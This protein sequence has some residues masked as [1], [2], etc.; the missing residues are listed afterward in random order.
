M[1]IKS[2]EQEMA[3]FCFNEI[4]SY[5]IKLDKSDELL[6]FKSDIRR[7]PAMI[8]N[9]GLLATLVFF[10]KSNENV[11]NIINGWFSNKLQNI[12]LIEYLTKENYEDLLFKTSEVLKLAN[13]LKRIVEVEIK[14]VKTTE[15]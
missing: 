2:I 13:W 11:Y 15:E 3:Q 9:N 6:K 4:S 10:K 12:D 8:T 5:K 7:L 1:N 14:D